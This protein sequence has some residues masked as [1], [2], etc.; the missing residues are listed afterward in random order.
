M[1]GSV[2]LLG[3]V[4]ILKPTPVLAQTN[5]GAFDVPGVKDPESVR[6]FMTGVPHDQGLRVGRVSY[7]NYNA[8]PPRLKAITLAG[9]Q[10][11][12]VRAGEG[13]GSGQPYLAEFV[14]ASYFDV[15]GVQLQGRAFA[16]ASDDPA[17]GSL[18]AVISH[19]LADSM[20]GRAA[21]ALGRSLTV[22]GRSVV[23]VGVAAPDFHGLGPRGAPTAVWLPGVSLPI[24]SERPGLRSDDRATGGYYEFVARQAPGTTW[25]DAT[26]ELTSSTR[27]LLQEYPAENAKFAEVGFHFT[28]DLF[29]ANR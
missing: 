26:E 20:F 1:F 29:C 28:H 2:A 15:L 8:L 21:S 27:W 3:A 14:T 4:L 10:F 9:F 18:E 7:L 6:R 25:S 12:E 5:C 22:N 13:A 17:T 19:A 23:I 24:L 11:M 16:I